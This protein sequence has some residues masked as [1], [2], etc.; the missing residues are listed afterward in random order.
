[1]IEVEIVADV[2][3]PMTVAAGLVRLGYLLAQ[4]RL[5]ADRKKVVQEKAALQAE[6]QQLDRTRRIR[7][8]FMSARR[9][10]QKEAM[11]S[12]WPQTDADQDG[13]E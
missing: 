12:A 10:M 1:V 4:E 3:V 9:A 7:A 13:A 2:A 11:R 5:Y 6:W 8:V